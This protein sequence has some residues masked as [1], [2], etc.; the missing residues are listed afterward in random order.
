MCLWPAAA[1]GAR[2]PL[3][4]KKLVGDFSGPASDR[5]MPNKNR[6]L[7]PVNF[8]VKKQKKRVFSVE[9]NFF[10]LAAAF[11]SQY[12]FY[13]LFC[14]N[15]RGF[16]QHKEVITMCSVCFQAAYFF[17]YLF[18]AS[19]FSPGVRKTSVSILYQRKCQPHQ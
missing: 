4:K 3:Q 5:V 15:F 8:S 12:S 19:N 16:V 10:P 14:R 1:W 7:K 18:L 13:F 9:R 17:L 11:F 6:F 2:V